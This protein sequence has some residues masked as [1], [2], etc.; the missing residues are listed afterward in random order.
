MAQ[1]RHSHEKKPL[2]GRKAVGQ[3]NVYFGPKEYTKLL[4]AK[5]VWIPTCVGMMLL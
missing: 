3:D 2:C 4:A 1:E 5:S